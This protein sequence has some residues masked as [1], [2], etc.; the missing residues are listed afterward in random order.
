MVFGLL[1]VAAI[2]IGIVVAWRLPSVNLLPSLIVSVAAAFVL[3]LFGISA[4]RRA[5]FRVDRSV[6]RVG[7]RTA[8]LGRFLVWVGF[9]FA[10]IGALA[11]GFYGAIRARS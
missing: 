4:A 6:A 10:I 8:R 3:S 9:Y 2:P 5:R 7:E 11:L 1:A